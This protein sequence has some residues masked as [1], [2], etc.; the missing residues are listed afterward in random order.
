MREC[1]YQHSFICTNEPQTNESQTRR[2]RTSTANTPRS[3]HKQTIISAVSNTSH[4]YG[5]EHA[6]QTHGHDHTIRTHIM[7]TDTSAPQTHHEHGHEWHAPQSTHYEHC[8][9]VYRIPR[10]SFQWRDARLEAP[11]FLK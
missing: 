1:F 3:R 4:V 2:T 7:S 8:H 9:T 5:H 11:Y 6:P 10:I